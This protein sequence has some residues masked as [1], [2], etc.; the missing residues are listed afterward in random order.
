M[1]ARKFTRR[2]TSSRYRSVRRSR[3]LRRV[4]QTARW[5]VGRI[6]I[7]AVRTLENSSG[8]EQ[9]TYFHVASIATSLGATFVA[10]P[11]QR[12]GAVLTE[13]NRRLEI[14]GVVFDYDCWHAGDLDGESDGIEDQSYDVHCS[15]VVDRIIKDAGAGTPFPASVVSYTPWFASFPSAA[16][17]TT[18]PFDSTEPVNAPTRTFWERN[19]FVD[20]RPKRI[21]ND[22]EG[23]LYVPENQR[24]ATRTGTLNRRLKL[25]LDEAQGLYFVWGTRTSALFN[26]SEAARA[27]RF[28][29]LGKVYYRFRQ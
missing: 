5:E 25:S 21:L 20:F 29:L 4:V 27:V 19:W 6:A 26:A 18:G 17:L 7:D 10:G 24:L 3:P 11:E 2:A 13:M 15:L 23:V 16:L 8:A 9:L 28:R 12:I 22:E 14:G 1:Y